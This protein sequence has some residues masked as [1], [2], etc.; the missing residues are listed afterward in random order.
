MGDV[1]ARVR[2]A[3]KHRFGRWRGGRVEG[4]RLRER[5][6]VGRPAR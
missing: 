4:D 1:E 5:A 2:H 3:G 6:L